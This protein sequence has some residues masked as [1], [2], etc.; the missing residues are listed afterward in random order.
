MKKNIVII[1][2]TM[3]KGGNSEILAQEFARGA[4]DAGNQVEII[5]L[6]DIKMQFCSGCLA[7][8]NLKHCVI[9]DDAA[10]ITETVRNADI[11]VFATP[12]YYYAMCGQLKTFIDR[13][14][15]I[16]TAGHSF[17]DIYL[18]ATSADNDTAAMDG[19]IKEIQGLIDCFDGVKLT[20]VLYGI[21]AVNVGDIHNCKQTLVDAYKMG[22]EIG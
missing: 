13:M 7:C 2:S 15:P 3:R 19:A 16:Y 5:Y 8:N 18:L 6:R 11:L 22:N 4:K 10:K 9:D 20:K 21:G 12:I 1:S 14:N 17:T